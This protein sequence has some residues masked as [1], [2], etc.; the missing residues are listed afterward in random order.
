MEEQIVSTK[1]ELFTV[2]DK[3]TDK[4]KHGEWEQIY[5]P[6]DPF[7]T[8]LDIRQ[9]N[10]ESVIPDILQC[11]FKDIKTEEVFLLSIETYHGAGGYLKRIHIES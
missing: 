7:C 6:T 4:I 3:I 11:Y 1:S 8:L 10:S 5:L 2:I 9:V